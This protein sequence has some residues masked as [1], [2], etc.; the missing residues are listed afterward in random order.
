MK[1]FFYCIHTYDDIPTNFIPIFTSSVSQKN[2]S[3]ITISNSLPHSHSFNAASLCLSHLLKAIIESGFVSDQPVWC[4]FT[5]F[6]QHCC[7]CF[8]LLTFIENLICQVS[9]KNCTCII[10]LSIASFP[11]SRFCCYYFTGGGTERLVNCS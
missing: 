11:L 6:V 4:Y 1:L 10:S 7:C 9:C 8:C 5:L 2:L 3:I